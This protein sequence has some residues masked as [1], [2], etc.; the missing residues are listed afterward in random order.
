MAAPSTLFSNKLLASLPTDDRERLASSVTTVPVKHRQHVYK[1]G[2]TI[3]SLYFPTGGAWSLT[4]TMEDGA[5]AEVGT[6]GNEGL[7]GSSTFFGDRIS[8]TDV[9]VQIAGE[10][11]EAIKMSVP[12]F[13]AEMDRHGAFYNRII[14]YH[15]ALVIQIQQTTVCNALHSVEQ[16]CCRWLLMMRDRLGTNEL[17]LTHDFMAIMLGVRRPTVSLIVGALQRA[18][19]IQNRRGRIDIVD[20]KTL[21]QA[22]CECYAAVKGSFARLLPEIPDAGLTDVSIGEPSPTGN[23]FHTIQ[24]H[25]RE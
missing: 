5:T 17:E 10:K 18:G 1:H 15:Q 12:A 8:S 9:I 2:D 14:R 11:P 22:S 13:I 7:I 19:L 16:R 3:D 20:E 4:K 21:E 6:I 24:Q 25:I 23:G